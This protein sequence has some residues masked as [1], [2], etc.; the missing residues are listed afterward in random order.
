[1]R[2]D[3]R[4]RSARLL[5]VEDN[6][7][8]AI[9]AKRAFRLGQLPSEI[10]VA[11]TAESGL[12]ILR[13]E[14]AYSDAPRPDLILLDLNLPNMNGH[15]FLKIIKNDSDLRCI[16]VI[17]LSSSSADADVSRSYQRFANGYIVKPAAPDTYS[18]VVNKIE[19]YWFSLM[20]MPPDYRP[21]Q[22]N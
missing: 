22:L 11:E 5:L 17:V 7:G 3:E 20:Q 10:M 13:R 19:Q 2:L 6:R 18:D 21:E 4:L 12:S 14:G 9:L 15:E 1:M 16:P 8:D